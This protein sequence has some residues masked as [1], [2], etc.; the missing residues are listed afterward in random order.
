[1]ESEK[2]NQMDNLLP[3]CNLTSIINFPVRVQNTSATATDNIFTDTSQYI[4]I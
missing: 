4:S 1:M 2:K 3:S